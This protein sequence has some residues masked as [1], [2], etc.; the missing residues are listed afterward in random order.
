MDI[1][2]LLYIIFPLPCLMQYFVGVTIG[3]FVGYII[4]RNS[5]GVEVEE[6]GA[7]RS[8]FE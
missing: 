3:I 4:G 2:K 8:K 1:A 7:D 5:R 6:K